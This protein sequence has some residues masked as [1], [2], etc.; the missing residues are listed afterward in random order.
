MG[1]LLRPAHRERP[2]RRPNGRSRHSL[3][4]G[5][6]SLDRDEAVRRS[7]LAAGRSNCPRFQIEN[8]IAGKISNSERLPILPEFRSV[9][10]VREGAHCF[11]VK[12]ALDTLGEACQLRRYD[13]NS[14]QLLAPQQVRVMLSPF[15][16]TSFLRRPRSGRAPSRNCLRRRQSRAENARAHRSSRREPAGF[17]AR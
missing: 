3:I 1:C 7:I 13:D 5:L 11:L 15:S 14:G 17:H 10:L 16:P 2:S 9:M 8:D 4:C 12:R 6:R